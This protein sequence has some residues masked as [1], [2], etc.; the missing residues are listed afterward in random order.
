MRSFS[1]RAI[2]STFTRWVGRSFSVR[3]ID[4]TC[5]TVANSRAPFKSPAMEPI[6]MRCHSASATQAV[7][8]QKRTKP[9]ISRLPR[10]WYATYNITSLATSI[11][12][13]RHLCFSLKTDCAIFNTYTACAPECNHHA[14]HVLVAPSSSGLM[15]SAGAK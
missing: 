9:R 4:L 3:F 6:N 10:I 13:L 12:Q 8:Q 5:L 15:N 2:H 7:T 14:A 1:I 11:H